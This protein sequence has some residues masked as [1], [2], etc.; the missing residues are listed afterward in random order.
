MFR[1]GLIVLLICGIEVFVGSYCLKG[2]VVKAAEASLSEEVQSAIAKLSAAKVETQ[3]EGSIF[4]RTTVAEIRPAIPRIVQAIAN[5]GPEVRMEL[6]L[7]LAALGRIDFEWLTPVFSVI[8]ADLQGNNQPLQLALVRMVREVKGLKEEQMKLLK[9]MLQSHDSQLQ[10]AVAVTLSRID[11][12]FPAYLDLQLLLKALT[13]EDDEE[14]VYASQALVAFTKIKPDT[15]SLLLK[16]LETKSVKVVCAAA[17]ALGEIGSPQAIGPL[18]IK[19]RDSDE[20]VRNY[21]AYALGK[22]GVAAFPELVKALREPKAEVR[23]VALAGLGQLGPAAEPAIP[24]MI[25]LLAD[26]ACHIWAADAI[27]E[28][29]GISAN[30]ILLQIR[31]CFRCF[32]SQFS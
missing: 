8:T 4:L 9:E 7:T 3:I 21:A 32:G 27:S 31:N 13:G 11:S 20:K 19:L 14:R 30:Q 12:T 5:V 10:T 28:C 24:I 23:R 2:A 22:I 18:A 17:L 26:E 25:G 29:R 6:Y 15:S 1:K 16:H